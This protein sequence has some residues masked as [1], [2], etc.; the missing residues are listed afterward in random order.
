MNQFQFKIALKVLGIHVGVVALVLIVSAL[1]GC[2]MP[3]PK[4]ELVTFVELCAAMPSTGESTE[5]PQ[6]QP[7]PRQQEPEQQPE[8][9]PEDVPDD[10]PDPDQIPETQ[11]EPEPRQQEPEPRQQ[12]PPP[13]LARVEDIVTG[14]RVNTERSTPQRNVSLGN[15]VGDSGANSGD[16]FS[17]YR[18]QIQKRFYNA[19]DRPVVE[20][21]RPA[22]VR[23]SFQSDGRISSRKLIQSSRDEAFD[24]SVMAAANRVSS[25]PRPPA[26]YS[27]RSA[28]IQFQLH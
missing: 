26:G 25:I 13:R 17:A 16:D 21:A 8:E 18:A 23:I 1:H 9:V 28:D 20:G 7:Q 15:I 2:F 24:R 10:I 6:Q 4:K 14:P 3:E 11:Q 27:N 19:W 12:E 22:I 5:E